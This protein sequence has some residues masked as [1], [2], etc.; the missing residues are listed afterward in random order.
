[1]VGDKIPNFILWLLWCFC[2]GSKDIAGK[3]VLVVLRAGWWGFVNCK[4]R[5][6]CTKV[7][8]EGVF[9]L[10]VCG[11]F[12]AP[13]FIWGCLWMDPRVKLSLFTCCCSRW[14]YLSNWWAKKGWFAHFW[15][16]RGQN[17]CLPEGATQNIS[18]TTWIKSQRRKKRNTIR[19]FSSRECDC[20]DMVM[21]NCRIAVEGN[22]ASRQRIATKCTASSSASLLSSSADHSAQLSCITVHPKWVHV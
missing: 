19:R 18:R 14:Y 21:H 5:P 2:S 20:A 3:S 12:F 15:A 17:K 4:S 22:A 8:P 1:M 10:G 9:V 11:A 7:N 16:T 6:M 13:L